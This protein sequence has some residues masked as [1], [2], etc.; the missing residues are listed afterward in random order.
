MNFPAEIIHNV[1]AI[2]DYTSHWFSGHIETEPGDFLWRQG[3]KTLARFFFPSLKEADPNELLKRIQRL[4]AGALGMDDE[5]RCLHSQC[6]DYDIAL[7][8][9]EPSTQDFVSDT[10]AA[11][12]ESPSEEKRD[13][14]GRLIARRLYAKTE[15]SEELYLR[16]AQS[17]SRRMNKRHLYAL[18]TL[19]L[20]RSAPMP[21]F[22]SRDLAY[23][24]LDRHLWPILQIVSDVDPTFEELNY[25]TSLGAVLYDGSDVSDSLSLSS[26]ASPI[27]QQIFNATHE[28]V[29]PAVVITDSKF[30]RASSEL[31]RGKISR[32][33]GVERIS[34][35]PYTLTLPGTTI[36][37]TIILAFLRA[38]PNA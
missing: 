25:L 9:T 12:M 13:L 29:S 4:E 19:S 11:M 31:Y 3:L 2:L 8:L 17:L 7:E 26:S 34:L 1:P 35:A 30:F 15:S 18:A 38:T 21:K 14:L 6:P 10:L 5:L 23:R 37:S 36:A 32:A 16:Q 27:E 20:V 22:E 28:F 24:W 33:K